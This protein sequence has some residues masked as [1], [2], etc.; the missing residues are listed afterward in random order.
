MEAQQPIDLGLASADLNCNLR[1]RHAVR[2]GAALVCFE[3]D[4]RCCHRT[5]VL[6]ALDAA[7]LTAESGL[8][9]EQAQP[10]YRTRS[11]RHLA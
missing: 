7:R 4:G 2:V 9:F 10:H 3:A 8:E 6:H 1:L 11:R 5:E